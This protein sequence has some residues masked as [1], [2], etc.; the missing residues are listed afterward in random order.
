MM[1]PVTPEQAREIAADLILESRGE[2]AIHSLADQVEAL[3]T[4]RDALKD[5]ARL[6]LDVIDNMA[7]FEHED[8][9]EK[10]ISEAIAALKAVL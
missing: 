5:A 7:H 6:A 2:A 10:P 4:E 3:T 9:P 1:T 8:D